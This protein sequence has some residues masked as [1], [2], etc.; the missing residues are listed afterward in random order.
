[1]RNRGDSQC[2]RIS[3][4]AGHAGREKVPGVEFLHAA[5]GGVD[6]ETKPLAA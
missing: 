3:L 4:D 6:A 2:E 5:R 1:M